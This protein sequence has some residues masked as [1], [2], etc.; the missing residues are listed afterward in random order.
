MKN[1]Y[2]NLLLLALF[3]TI[4]LLFVVIGEKYKSSYLAATF[5]RE[6]YKNS[7][8]A[9]S[10]FQTL[11]QAKKNSTLS[12]ALL[13]SQN[14]DL[15]SAFISH[16]D[17]AKQ[18]ENYSI[19]L[20]QETDFK[21]VWFQLIDPKGLVIARSWTHKKGEELSKIRK[22]VQKEI[23]EPH[24]KTSVNVGDFDLAIRTMVPLY[25]KKHLFLGYLEVIT[26]FNSIAQ[27]MSEDGFE[28]IVLADKS[29]K[30]Q[31]IHPFSEKFIGEYYLANKNANTSYIDYISK[32]GV[33]KFLNTNSHY[34]VDQS[35]NLL[36]SN[37]TIFDTDEK[38]M[39][40]VLM[41]QKINL[42]A[43]TSM[44]RFINMVL[45]FSIVILLF[46]YLLLFN[47][48]ENIFQTKG[49]LSKYSV[50][51]I[52]IFSLAVIGNW[53]I[54]NAYKKST[55]K[56][57]LDQ[58]NTDLQTDYE[59]VYKNYRNLANR[60]FQNDINKPDVA[61]LMH[62]AYGADKDQAREKLY[63]HFMFLYETYK[64]YGIQQLH[65]HLKNN[66]SFLR[67][68]RP[69]KYGENLSQIRHTVEYVNHNLTPTEGFE[70]GRIYDG[71]CYVY[72]LF[73][74]NA[75]GVKEHVGSV[76]VSLSAFEM[77][78][79]FAVIHKAKV[80]FLVQKNVVDGKVFKEEA[81]NYQKSDFKNFYYEKTTKQQ[82]ENSCLYFDD[83]KLT[84]MQKQFVSDEILKGDIFTLADKDSGAL[85]SFMP[86]RNPVT[87]NISAVL[88]FE[89]QNGAI[90]QQK[91]LFTLFLAGGTVIILILAL[92]IFREFA[93][94][95]KLLDLSTKTQK[96]LDMQNSIIVITNGLKL[97]DSNKKFLEFFDYESIEKFLKNHDCI[98]DYFVEDERYYSLKKVPP[99]H[100]WI[101]YL[102]HLDE[103]NR[104]V[105]MADKNG[106]LHS[107]TIQFNKY[108]E[109]HI[110]TF[111]DITQTMQENIALEGKAMHDT[112]TGIY[113]RAFFDAKIENIIL[114]NQTRDTL[115][116]IIFFDID[117]FKNVNDTYGHE[118]G[119]ITLK[120][121]VRVV[122][123]STRKSDFV[124]R[125]G[126]EEFIILVSVSD[127]EELYKIAQN[128]RIK[129]EKHRFEHIQTLTCSFGATL[130]QSSEGI[131]K[132]V[133]RADA[134]LY[135]S[136][137]NGR[138]RV[139]LS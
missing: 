62:E 104:I 132:S 123:Q 60:I 46:L 59:F 53:A 33:E 13:L 120:E 56:Q 119:D 105:L 102:E 44:V 137:E 42:A 136:K 124:I 128:L 82:L 63:Q 10:S 31:F 84:Q 135:L 70:E 16:S 103:K 11:L 15:K 129:I 38:P 28:T 8:T 43:D 87:H 69:Q 34:M 134:A 94:K 79:D 71:F 92:F 49:R 117:H 5:D 91:Q 96:I 23:G 20:G 48:N 114:E 57:Y 14:D 100:N 25:G 108:G 1:R 64:H 109:H 54:L 131:E 77:V 74:T 122:T 116:G 67:F 27:K 36:I 4:A 133:K 12:I 98:C 80:G 97:E 88:V 24:V 66:E 115:L 2:W 7:Q 86:L 50:I 45:F 18:L 138:N 139:T 32:R 81:S 111:T 126:G 30:N 125:W 73:Y 72:P 101:S 78:K 61:A 19:Q 118:V 22:D 65:F 106:V 26:H 107:F 55:Q 47:K 130:H 89:M 93:Q 21:N 99:E 29:Y 83:K 9:I 58:Y 3:T 6:C 37:L 110:V 39:A 35:S 75:D 40:Y 68:N 95:I 127:I 121:L 112:L 113:N 90:Q 52:T 76:E 17:V 51:F 41:F 85:F